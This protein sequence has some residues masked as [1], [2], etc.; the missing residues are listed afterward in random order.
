M[1]GLLVRGLT[2]EVGMSND[3]YGYVTAK[4]PVRT[5]EEL[6]RIA[7][8]LR[9]GITLVAK[10]ELY[11]F[12]PNRMPPEE[13][14]CFVLGDRPGKQTADYLTDYVDY[15]PEAN[16]GLPLK[17]RD[18]LQVLLAW[19]R[20]TASIEGAGLLAIAITECSEI[21]KEREVSLAEMD[22][23]IEQDFQDYAPPNTLYLFQL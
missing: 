22:L 10:D 4:E 18:R 17:G 21:E 13:A 23:V 5:A 8:Q 16:I 3:V 12:P 19:M 1:D 14:V 6:N 20:Q 9:L 15:A 2:I 11:N 7:E